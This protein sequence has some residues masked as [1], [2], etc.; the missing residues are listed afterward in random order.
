MAATMSALL[1]NNTK[2]EGGGMD[3]PVSPTS[4]KDLLPV[5]SDEVVGLATIATT[6]SPARSPPRSRRHTVDSGYETAQ[7]LLQCQQLEREFEDEYDGAKAAL[8]ASMHNL[9]A[10]LRLIQSK[11]DKAAATIETLQV[12]NRELSSAVGSLTKETER[13]HESMAK[14]T[15]RLHE[16]M[17]ELVIVAAD[18]EEGCGED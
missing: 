12:E 13:L 8:D 1:E 11:N 6:P 14:E 4:V 2:L 7:L 17:N 3:D 15:E 5:I 18:G 10:G 16:S 9:A